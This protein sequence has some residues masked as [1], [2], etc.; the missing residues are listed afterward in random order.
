MSA[1]L[2]QA[3]H[4][5]LCGFGCSGYVKTIYVGYQLGEDMVAALYGHPDHLE[6][7]LALSEDDESDLLVDASHLTWR[8]LP[9]AARISK[10]DE[11]QA[12]ASL[13]EKAAGRLRMG[14]HSV[15]RD[16][17]YF[18]RARKNRRNLGEEESRP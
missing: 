3:A 5:V 11:M 2:A 14:Q 13:A 15:Y 4:D 12:F 9:V 10:M 16:N 18:V 7:A 8:T 17:D 1:E 6:I